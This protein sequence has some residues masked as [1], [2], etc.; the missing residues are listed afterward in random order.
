MV[1]PTCRV[2]SWVVAK[3]VGYAQHV[4][5]TNLLDFALVHFAL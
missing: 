4:L 2:V 1:I 3:A 5:L